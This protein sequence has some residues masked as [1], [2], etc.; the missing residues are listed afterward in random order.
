[1]TAIDRVRQIADHAQSINKIEG[2]A[3]KF[4]K[5]AGLGYYSFSSPIWANYGLDRGL[6]I[7]CFGSY[8]GDSI[9][10]IVYANSEVAVM[11]KYGG[12]TSGYFG[13]IRPRGRTIT[14][15]GK[16]DG[17]FN[18]TRLF[19]TTINVISQ[20][21]TRRG[22][23]AGYIDVEHADIEEWLYPH[24]QQPLCQGRRNWG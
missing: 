1:M 3:D 9:E 11:S 8:I 4:F 5:Y 15:N 19:D 10:E 12:G 16:S 2:F 24:C 17:S 22:Q 21:T 20:G 13:D 18:F 23:F 6:P 14:N 7:S